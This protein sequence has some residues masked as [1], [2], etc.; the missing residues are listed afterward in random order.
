MKL[1]KRSLI[2][3]VSLVALLVITVGGTLAYIAVS[4]GSLTNIFNPSKVEVTIQ[5]GTITNTGNAPAYVRVAI[6][7]NW[8]DS[9]DVVYA[10]APSYT[11]TVDSTGWTKGSDGFYYYT[12]VLQPEDY[13]TAPVVALDDREEAPDGGY[14]FTVEIL[15]SAI[16]ATPD[17]VSDW[18]TAVKVENGILIPK[19]N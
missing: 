3:L 1:N 2:L 19:T 12:Q 6:V 13:I 14:T 5:D 18:S 8:R 17:A 9:N 10:K 7:A 11:V 15:A 16:Q 4:T